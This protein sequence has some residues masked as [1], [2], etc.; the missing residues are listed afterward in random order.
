[1]R[2][3]DMSANEALGIVHASEQ[4]AADTTALVDQPQ[5]NGFPG[6]AA[7]LSHITGITGGD[8]IVPH[9]A[10]IAS[11]VPVNA[12][13]SPAGL[14]TAVL[15][16]LAVGGLFLFAA[17]RRTTRSRYRRMKARRR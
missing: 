2:L 8:G 14:T 4:R 16:V 10:T 12:Q 1:M 5:S 7:I 15:G 13:G 9:Q 6:F 11:T 17:T 3:G